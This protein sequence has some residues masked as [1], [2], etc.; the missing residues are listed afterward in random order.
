MANPQPKPQPRN[1]PTATAYPEPNFV[2]L[3][4]SEVDEA[5]FPDHIRKK[6][7]LDSGVP[8][9]WKPEHKNEY[10]TAYLAMQTT[11]SKG[12]IAYTLHVLGDSN[13]IHS[14]T[15]PVLLKHGGRVLENRMEELQVKAGDLVC[16]MF[17][18][19]GEAKQGQSA[20]RLWKVRK[21]FVE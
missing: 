10:V 6:A 19:Y 21:L 8:E 16:I 15:K 2:E 9:E 11:M 4:G 12:G 14:A 18:G 3:A 1:A 13:D 5:P 20:P 7:G 17:L